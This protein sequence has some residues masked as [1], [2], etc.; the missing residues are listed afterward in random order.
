ML[1]ELKFIAE[2]YNINNTNII[3]QNYNQFIILLIN[4]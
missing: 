2:N 1:S 4:Q 3:R